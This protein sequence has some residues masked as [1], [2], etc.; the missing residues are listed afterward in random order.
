[1]YELSADKE[2]CAGCACVIRT[3]C[4]QQWLKKDSI[5]ISDGRY[6][7]EEVKKAVEDAIESCPLKSVRLRRIVNG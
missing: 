5:I 2:L 3:P 1:M 4:F 6:E 7:E